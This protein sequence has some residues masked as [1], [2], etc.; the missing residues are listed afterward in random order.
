MMLRVV[1]AMLGVAAA[2]LV[3]QAVAQADTGEGSTS[4]TTSTSAS[5][6]PDPGAAADGGTAPADTSDPQPPSTS[7][8]TRSAAPAVAVDRPAMRFSARPIAVRNPARTLSRAGHDASNAPGEDTDVDGR[9]DAPARPRDADTDR[10]TAEGTV[11]ADAEQRYPG[12]TAAASAD[13]VTAAPARRQA[14][15]ALRRQ[16]LD[17]SPLLRTE[18]AR[19]EPAREPMNP[20]DAA[21]SVLI[22]AV[23]AAVRVFDPP[24]TI[25]STSSVTRGMSTLDV[26]CGCGQQL[27]ADWYFPNQPEEP[28]GTIYLQHGFLRSKSNMSGLAVQLAEHTNSIVV[29]P[30]VSSNPL[31]PDGCW[32]NG[33]PMHRAVANLFSGDRTALTDSAS[34]AAGRPVTLPR[35]YVIAGHSAGGNLA[36][37]AAGYTTT[38]DAVGDL[39]AV[40]MFDGVDNGGAIASAAGRL[41]GAYD[42]PIYQIAGE[43]SSCNAFGSGTVALTDARPDRFVGVRLEGGTHVDAEGSSA[44]PLAWLACGYPQ[45]R[46]VEAVPAIAAGWIVDAFTG[47]DVGVYGEPGQRI[48]VGGATAVVLGSAAMAA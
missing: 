15:A 4:A 13:S 37:A 39:R 38:S 36:A 24:P 16:I 35:Q 45:P 21:G 31:D 47:S 33:D 28:V 30:T 44:G 1:A 11:E 19:I 41:T 10:E 22:D 9:G 14:P 26:G 40:V 34:A 42:R 3:G 43:C 29:V 5:T 6:G 17:R 46:N 20:I 25:P 12:R 48:P 32:I 8:D 7:A 2:L 18:S 27:E 23:A